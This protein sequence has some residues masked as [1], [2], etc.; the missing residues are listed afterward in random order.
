MFL[1]MLTALRPLYCKFDRA[2]TEVVYRVTRPTD[3]KQ[4]YLFSQPV[5]SVGMKK[6]GWLHDAKTGHKI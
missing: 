4:E 5:A 1:E 3:T 6:F 2:K